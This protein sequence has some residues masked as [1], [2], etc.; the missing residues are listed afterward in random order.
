VFSTVATA[1]LLGAI[2]IFTR[3]SVEKGIN[4]PQDQ[5]LQA[6]FNCLAGSSFHVKI[7]GWLNS[8]GLAN[9]ATWNPDRL[10]ICNY[11]VW[12][13]QLPLKG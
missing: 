11:V 6:T 7:G 5:L 1:V 13:N 12:K 3:L 10:T 4:N 2:A 8:L 9:N